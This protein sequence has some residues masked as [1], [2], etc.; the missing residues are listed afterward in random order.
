VSEPWHDINDPG[1]FFKPEPEPADNT[2]V[3]YKT[4]SVAESKKEPQP[5][6]VRL[7]EGKFLQP[8]DCRNFNDKCKVQVKVEYLRETSLKKITFSLFCT[9]N[10]KTEQM[11]PD[12]EG[13]EKNGIAEAEFQLFYPENYKRGD[14]ADYFF[15]V[16]H[17]RGEKIIESEE[18]TLPIEKFLE[19]TITYSENT[20]KIPGKADQILKDILSDAGIT[21]VI[22]TS[23]TRSPSDQARIMY[24]NIETYGV[25]PQK[26]LYAASG[27]EVI[28]IYSSLKKEGKTPDE[29]KN[30]MEQKI[31]TIGPSKVSAHC[32]DISKKCVFDIAPSSVPADKKMK[33]E[34][35]VGKNKKVIKFL[36]P[37]GDPAYHIEIDL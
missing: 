10:G 22:I 36:K 6:E 19:V 32:A 21:S 34:D 7:S 31:I 35:A 1:A 13:F 4:D 9:Y 11:K 8:E 2:R 5:A 15:K 29:I 33:F 26:E 27:N 20:S 28:D 30:G 14:K 23:T 3:A 37:P 12:K 24:S 25:D 17:R 16:E 18:L